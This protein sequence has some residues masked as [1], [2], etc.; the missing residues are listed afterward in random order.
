MFV[1]V[2]NTNIDRFM[3]KI[4]GLGYQVIAEYRRYD[5]STN[6]LIKPIRRP[7]GIGDRLRNKWHKQ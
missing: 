3:S 1:E 4:V 5:E 2:A 6:L 7:W